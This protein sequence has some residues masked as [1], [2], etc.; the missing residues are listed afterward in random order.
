MPRVLLAEDDDAVRD[1]LQTS[2]ERDGFEV[3][4][5]A[6][7]CDAL[8]HIASENFDVLLSDLHMPLAGDGFTVVSAMRHTHPHAVTLV[9][10]GYPELDEA[11]SAIRLQADEVLVKPIQI[12]SL[13]EII[14]DKLSHP[15]AYPPLRHP[16]KSVASILEQDLEATIQAWM[17]LVEADAELTC[18]PLS[19]VER[20][21]HLPGLLADLIYRLRLPRIAKA[22][23]SIAARQHGTLR[24]K[25]GYTAAMIVEE[26]RIL[27]VSIFKTLQNNLS[28][29]DFSKVLLDVMTI[30]DE[31]DS[32]LKEAMFSYVDPGPGSARSE[33]A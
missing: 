25:Q 28:S 30:A 16:T 2:L 17:G 10:S 7:V 26:S 6:N 18:I 3:V 4:A 5:V 21:G 29:V 27:Q 24:R 31:V 22:D 8:S 1:M 11:L 23:F 13:R 15:V 14:H 19:F 33:A 32:Q 12:A 9:L 20:T